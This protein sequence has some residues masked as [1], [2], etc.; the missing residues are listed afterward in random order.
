[1]NCFDWPVQYWL[2]FIVMYI[3][4]LYQFVF[5]SIRYVVN[6]AFCVQ[7]WSLNI[8]SFFTRFEVLW[9][10]NLNASSSWPLTMSYGI[11]SPAVS[12]EVVQSTPHY[13]SPRRLDTNVV[14]KIPLCLVLWKFL[15]GLNLKSES[16]Q[17]AVFYVIKLLFYE[18]NTNT[19]IV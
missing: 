8:Y 16:Y 9:S 5:S 6:I 19:N 18:Y 15:T 14:M 13:C 7:P 2:V 1:M 10:P 12:S 17:V 3:D 11:S 4:C